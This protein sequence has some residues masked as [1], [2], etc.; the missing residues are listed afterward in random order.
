[1]N[2]RHKV[3]FAIATISV[4]AAGWFLRERIRHYPGS[5][6][7]GRYRVYQKLSTEMC[8]HMLERHRQEAE[9]CW[10][11][12][13]ILIK[14]MRDCILSPDGVNTNHILRI[15]AYHERCINENTKR[16]RKKH[17][18]IQSRIRQGDK[19]YYFEYVKRKGDFSDDQY[20]YSDWGILIE[21][22]SEVVYRST[23]GSSTVH[24]SMSPPVDSKDVVREE[25]A[26]FDHL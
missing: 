19:I 10:D 16:V 3:V 7:G 17:G 26:N 4:L 1:M 18:N 13:G 8:M 22:D 23:F 14:Q 12:E 20:E 25:D 24:P 15:L 9:L 5:L 21:R 2:V 11:L 6:H